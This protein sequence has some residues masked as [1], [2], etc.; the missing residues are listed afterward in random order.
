MELS[1]RELETA[2]PRTGH[3]RKNVLTVPALEGRG[4]HPER[5]GQARKLSLHEPREVK[6]GQV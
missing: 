1:E 5:R 6:Q 4:C 2:W 3:R